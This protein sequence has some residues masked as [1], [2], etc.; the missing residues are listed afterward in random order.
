MSGILKFFKPVT[1]GNETGFSGLTS[2]QIESADTEVSKAL[3]DCQGRKR[4]KYSTYTDEK[5]ASMLPK[6]AI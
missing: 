3:S 5:L 1:T 4:K 2:R 6:T